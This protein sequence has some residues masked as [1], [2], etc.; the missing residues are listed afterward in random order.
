MTC[1]FSMHPSRSQHSRRLHINGAHAYFFLLAVVI[2]C[3]LLVC[4]LE[5]QHLLRQQSVIPVAHLHAHMSAINNMSSRTN[6]STGL[7]SFRNNG[8]SN[9]GTLIFI[10]AK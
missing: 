7:M 5:R 1:F 6:T 10:T 4:R 3:H 8:L 2:A 9:V